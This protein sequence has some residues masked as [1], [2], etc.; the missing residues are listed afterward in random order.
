MINSL[1]LTLSSKSNLAPSLRAS[2][3]E[4]CGSRYTVIILVSPIDDIR[5]DAFI[6]VTTAAP[7]I[8][9]QE[10]R[11]P[12]LASDII[13]LFQMLFMPSFMR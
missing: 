3:S 5:L 4:I 13:R 6:D 9:R 1:D 12:I 7:V 10:I 11:T 2:T 8:K